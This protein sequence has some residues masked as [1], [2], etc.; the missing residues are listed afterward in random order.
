MKRE[1]IWT[2]AAEVDAQEAFVQMEEAVE[3]SGL[4]LIQLIDQL[5]LLLSGFPHMAPVWHSP[6][7]KAGLRKT[8][9]GAFYVPESTR[10]VIIGVQDLRAAPDRLSR[11][12]K[13]RLP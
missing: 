8:K 11:E 4:H 9:Y 13:R 7:R 1:V 12:L 6:V 3:G 2:W 5:I 10:L